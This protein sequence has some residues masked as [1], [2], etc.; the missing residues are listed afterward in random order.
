MEPLPHW[1]K[2]LGKKPYKG[3]KNSP[4]NFISADI[5]VWLGVRENLRTDLEAVL[6]FDNGDDSEEDSEED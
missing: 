2:H 4:P 5:P 3:V 1:G 6:Y